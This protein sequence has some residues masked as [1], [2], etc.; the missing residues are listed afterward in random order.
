MKQLI[1]TLLFFSV[2][3]SSCNEQNISCDITVTSNF[4][5]NVEIVDCLKKSLVMFSGENVTVLATPYNGYIFAGWYAGNNL[6]SKETEYTFVVSE[7]I[8]L[9]A[10][11]IKKSDLVNGHEAVDLGLPSGVKW[12]S[13]NV[14]ASSPEEYG[15]YYAWGETEEKTSYRWGTYKW[16]NGSYDT[17]TKYCNDNF[18]GAIDNKTILDAEDDVA[19]VK[20][21][22]RWRMP[23][24]SEQD[25]LRNKCDWE[26]ASINGV[27]GYKVKS[28]INDN[29]IF[30]PAAGYRDATDTP[31]VGL[32]GIYWS[33]SLGDFYGCVLAN[34]IGFD[35]NEYKWDVTL[36][37]YG[38][39]VRPVCD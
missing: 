12:A 35:K 7:S 33:S 5:G 15:G 30:L 26:W 22:G 10:K 3:F 28:R 21:G 9:F 14:G 31:L 39:S 13:C 4:G 11:F 27:N 6:L 1:K 37:N 2:L 17:L 32:N 24:R 16:C 19:T 18:Y 8:D 36:R 29:W 20:W 38:R 25:E 34:L 23:T